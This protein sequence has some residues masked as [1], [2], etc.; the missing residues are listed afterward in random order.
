MKRLILFGVLCCV[1]MVG[2][3]K[4]QESDS[5]Q[6]TTES[7]AEVT[8][9][10]TQEDI[11]ESNTELAVEESTKPYYV[12]IE[13]IYYYD[14]DDSWKYFYGT[15]STGTVVGDDYPELKETVDSFFAD[16][17][18]NYKTQVA[19]WL[20]D[21][22]QQQQDMGDETL[23][24]TC[25]EVVRTARADSR[26]LSLKMTEDTYLG[27]AHGNFSTFGNTLDVKT[28]N[29]IFFEDLGDIKADVKDCVLEYL[30][31]SD[32]KDDLN[33]DYAETIEA[34]INNNANWYLTGQGLQF[35]I[36]EYEIAAY[37]VGRFDIGIPYDKM[38]GFNPQYL[39]PEN[40]GFFVSI[41][42]YDSISVDIEG[43]GTLTTISYSMGDM[44]DDYGYS[45]DTLIVNGKEIS[46][47]EN[48]FYN[49]DAYYIETPKKEKYVIVSRYQ[50]NDYRSTGL[51]DVS[52]NMKEVDMCGLTIKGVFNDGVWASLKID[53]LGSFICS[54]YYKLEN[55]KFVAQSERFDLG[56]TKEAEYRK[57]PVLKQALT[58]K[59]KRDGV[60]VDEELTAG[61]RIY[62]INTDGTSVVGFE[63]EDGT[64]GELTME[65]VDYTI[66]I[67]GI[68]EYD[69]FDE[70]MY[71]G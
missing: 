33:L 70:L 31:N 39:P 7:V 57:G 61:T 46:L 50:D 27:G 54:D 25:H 5:T 11:T 63:L 69:L 3:T 35:V 62:P 45:K 56:N 32:V 38:P 10:T 1:G 6:A 18:S 28:G 51:Y 55:G 59:L 22:K 13:D 41:P 44:V 65:R 23:K 29:Q 60:M 36:N 8:T 40:A 15:Y 47:G 14:D 48:Y 42:K 52:D 17:E 19:G 53:V 68:S 66:T 21:A 34:M 67:N 20:Q 4:T 26:V 24:Y 16:I 9:A 37:A 71:A 58:V 2:C 64:Y 43:D 30:E 12:S 49:A